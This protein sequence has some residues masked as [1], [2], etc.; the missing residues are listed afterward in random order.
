MIR[1]FI[2][3]NLAAPV[4]EEIAKVR[5]ALQEAKGDVRWTRSEGLHLTLKFLGDIARNQVE[6]ILAAIRE[7]LHGQQPLYLVAQGLGAFPNLRRPRVLWVGLSGEGLPEMRRAIE[8]ALMPLDFPPEEREFTPHL[9]LGR[10]RSLRGW[11]RLLA[12][13]K[14]YEQV[15][16]G[17]STVDQVIL[18][19]SELRPEG[20]VYSPL[21]AIPLLPP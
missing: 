4:I 19:Q 11:E 10:V 5:F 8:T 9:T 21:G 2:A 1:A 18:Y 7:A 15:C 6:P 14:A 20:A 13:V 17:E 12:V 16:F 3:V